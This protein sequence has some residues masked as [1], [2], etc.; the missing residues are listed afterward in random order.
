MSHRYY[1]VMRPVS[2]GT[3]PHEGVLEIK[4]F[5]K[6]EFIQEINH[7]AWGYI[8]YDR[9]LDE[10]ECMLYELMS[11]DVKTWYAV[12]ITVW[13]SDSCMNGLIQAKIMQERKQAYRPDGWE[14]RCKNMSLYCEWYGNI[15]DAK[16]AIDD[17]LS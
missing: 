7:A 8:E 10:S 14:R 13:D 15:K 2:L 3:F 17:A 12:M 4:N 1:S 11:A 5:D 6:R 9:V 16:D